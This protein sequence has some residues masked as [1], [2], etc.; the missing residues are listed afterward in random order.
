MHKTVTV[1]IDSREQKPLLFPEVIP[2][3][4]PC[5]DGP[6]ALGTRPVTVKV[7]TERQCLQWGDYCL[8]GSEATAVIERKSGLR[9]LAGNTLTKDRSRFLRALSRLAKNTKYPYLFIETLPSAWWRSGDPEV[10]E[11][12]DQFLSSIAHLGVHLLWNCSTTRT[13]RRRMGEL[14]L[15]ILLNRE[16]CNASN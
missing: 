12:I 5:G 1:I 16:F 11:T 13:N 9:E 7:K 3:W 8:K 14:A 2:F 10:A 4:L 15:R 6:S